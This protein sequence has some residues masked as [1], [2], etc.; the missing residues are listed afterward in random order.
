VLTLPHQYG[1]AALTLNERP[2]GRSFAPNGA[3]SITRGRSLG[4]L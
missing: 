2:A 3:T 4:K 1:P